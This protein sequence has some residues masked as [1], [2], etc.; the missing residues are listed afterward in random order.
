MEVKDLTLEVLVSI[1]D[2]IKALRADTNARFE[3][4]D[5]RF[6]QMDK[7]FEQMDKRFERIEEDISQIKK[8][9]DYIVNRFERDYL[10]LASQVDT[11]KKRLGV[12]EE[13]L[14]ISPDPF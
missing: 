3:Q 13:R 14:G 4:M 5:K 10:L 7:R 11:M 6:E 12:C 8:G 9:M 2:E 1:R